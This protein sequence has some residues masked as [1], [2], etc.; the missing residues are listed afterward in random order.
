MGGAARGEHRFEGKGRLR[1]LVT[2]AT[3]FL[4]SAVTRALARAGHSVRVLVRRP[5]RLHGVDGLGLDVFVGDVL[6]RP[7]VAAAAD[8]ADAIVHCAGLVSWRPRDR[9]ELHR[10]NVDGTIN[11]LDVA[12]DRGLRVLH[13]SSISTLGGT[14]RPQLFDEET[15]PVPL[16]FDCPY[17]ESKRTSERLARAHRGNVVVL[18][19]GIILG[20]GDAYL[21]SSQLVL[22]YLRGELHHHMRG[23]GTYCDVRDAADAYVAALER[24]QPGQHY[25]L[26][27][28][29]LSHEEF[30]EQLQRVTGLQR[31]YPLSLQV[32]EWA[33]SWS[34]AASV[35]GPHL[36]E[37]LSL[38][39]VRWGAL[40]TY[41]SSQKAERSLSYRRREFRETLRDTVFD[42]LRRGAA[43]PS[44]PELRR[45]LHG[46]S[47]DRA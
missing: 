17:T 11:V 6:R 12:A 13:T 28:T 38:P 9:P 14:H 43:R 15:P 22:R 39:V 47:W 16:P 4:G 41:T 44:S 32:A 33:A 36:L 24:W 34:E 35:F 19:P 10:A 27:G 42:L 8:G 7:M 20:P 45:L 5:E 23:G 21:T 40:Y 2:G 3:G 37:D 31:T 25:I 26:A 29:N 30:R 18:S 1:V 46:E